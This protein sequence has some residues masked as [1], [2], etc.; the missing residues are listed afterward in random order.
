MLK[1]MRGQAMVGGLLLAANIFVGCQGSMDS[2]A[3]HSP[4]DTLALET[5]AK[6]D[7]LA[8]GKLATRLKDSAK[9]KVDT[10]GVIKKILSF[11]RQRWSSVV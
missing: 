5:E 11:D 4:Q 2:K 7:T 3:A 6:Q 10:V 1:G 9:Q 8:K